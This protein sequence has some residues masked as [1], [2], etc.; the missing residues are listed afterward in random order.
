VQPDEIAF[1]D[2]AQPHV[3]A[4]AAYGMY[5]I[6][7]RDTAQAIADVQTCLQSGSR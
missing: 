2:D 7:F 1:L 3:A 4:A 5:A 6:L